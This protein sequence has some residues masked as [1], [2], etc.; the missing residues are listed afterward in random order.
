M[1][2]FSYFAQQPILNTDQSLYGYELLF[3]DSE[4]NVFP[5]VSSEEATARLIAE[6]LIG[7]SLDRLAGN[8][9]CFV[10]FPQESL[11]KQLPTMLPADQLVVEVLEDVEPSDEVINALRS[12]KEQGHTIA[13]DDYIHDPRW[14]QCVDFV[15]II[16]FDLT[17]QNWE[18]LQEYVN[19]FKPHNIRLL[20]ERV[21]TH[22]EFEK[23]KAMGFSLFQ[24]YFFSKP[25]MVR[26]RAM[27]ANE[28]T[29]IQLLNAVNQDDPDFSQ[30]ERLFNADVSLSYKLLRTL[31]NK[32]GHRGTKVESLQQAAIYLGSAELRKFVSLI[33]TRS[34]N[35]SSPLELS[36]LAMTRAYFCEALSKK[37]S[38]GNTTHG[39]MTGFFSL[40]EVLMER[41]LA[42]LIDGLPLTANVISA[43]TEEQGALGH[44]LKLCKAHEQANWQA[45][46]EQAS[47]LSLEPETSFAAY[48]DALQK[49]DEMIRLLN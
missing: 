11:L 9:R 33:A 42:E 34:V 13:L 28:L 17:Q 2:D 36:K 43:L 44:V 14:Q 46:D 48:S 45:V 16:K 37:M 39:F 22:E 10:N 24:G 38:G 21:E 7:Q 26:Q 8:V 5:K 19:L 18:Q 31:N 3:R 20:A 1:T 49:A 30:I 35:D 23:C 40:L 4:Q 32:L 47:A 25:Q 12:L 29:V 6:S 15:D 41:P 27:N